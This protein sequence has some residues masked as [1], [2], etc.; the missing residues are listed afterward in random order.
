VNNN[1]QAKQDMLT[2]R[3]SN[4]MKTKIKTSG[5]DDYDDDFVFY[6][7][8]KIKASNIVEIGY[9]HFMNDNFAL[10]IN[11]SL[12]TKYKLDYA[13]VSIDVVKQ[14]QLALTGQ[15]Y[16]DTT[17]TSLMPYVGAGIHYTKF[18]SWLNDANDNYDYSEDNDYS[19]ESKSQT[20]SDKENVGLVL[21]AGLYYDLGNNLFI[22]AE[23]KKSFIKAKEE[24]NI[25]VTITDKTNNQA[26]TKTITSKSTSK[27]SPFAIGIGIGYVF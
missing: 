1:D 15:Y 11:Y 7:T 26:I 12:P 8:P 20:K 25:F 2:I 23:A 9:V 5:D 17:A 14:S 16:F 22:N 21:Q 3:I 13:G 10:N 4:A 6:S 27:Y 24:E 18:S 19:Y